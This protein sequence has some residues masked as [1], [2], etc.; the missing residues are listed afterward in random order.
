MQLTVAAEAVRHYN[1]VGRTLTQAMVPWDLL[2]DNEGEGSYDNSKGT[3][4]SIGRRSTTNHIID[5]DDVLECELMRDF[6]ITF[7]CFN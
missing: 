6:L 7:Q 5:D 3:Y 1:A 2:E 4:Q